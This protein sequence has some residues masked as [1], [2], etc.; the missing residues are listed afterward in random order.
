MRAEVKP[1]QLEVSV[2]N[3]CP[4]LIAV[5]VPGLGTER[6]QAG[7]GGGQTQTLTF[8]SVREMMGALCKVQQQ[9]SGA[10]RAGR[11]SQADGG[12]SGESA[13]LSGQRDKRAGGG[14][15]SVPWAP[16]QPAWAAVLVPSLWH[17]GPLGHL[18]V[19]SLSQLT[20][21]CTM[22]LLVV[23]P[24]QSCQRVKCVEVRKVLRVLPGK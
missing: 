15:R 3:I 16:R 22:K 11:G 10:L 23:P 5:Q 14:R 7:P 18:P 21:S 4:V 19:L 2:W 9:H 17:L 12:E 20:W 1:T 6:T 8:R 24:P 13:G